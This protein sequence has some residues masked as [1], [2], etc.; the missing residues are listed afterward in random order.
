MLGIYFGCFGV[1]CGFTTVGF[2]FL[3]VISCVDCCA[4]VCFN[5]GLFVVECLAGVVWLRVVGSRVFIWVRWLL[6]TVVG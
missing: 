2:V 6:G 5:C 4:F 1:C 3:I